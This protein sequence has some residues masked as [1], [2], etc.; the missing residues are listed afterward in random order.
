M[1][2][3]I[4]LI[5]ICLCQIMTLQAET[6]RR[7]VKP[8]NE[9]ISNSTIDGKSWD[10]ASANLQEMIDEVASE[11]EK[12]GK[13]GE[14]W[15]AAGTYIPSRTIKEEFGEFKYEEDG[16]G[17]KNKSFFLKEGVKLYGG[18][19]GN[20]NNLNDRHWIEHKTILSGKFP[21]TN[22]YHVVISVDVKE[23]RLDGFY[24]E[25]GQATEHK[26]LTTKKNLQN[27][28]FFCGHGGGLYIYKSSPTLAQ[29]IIRNN[30]TVQGG[31][32]IYLHE[33]RS[34]IIN[35]LLYGNNATFLNPEVCKEATGAGLFSF[36]SDPI[37]IH[38]TIT[39]NTADNYGAGIDVVREQYTETTLKI[40]NS[41]IYGNTR[42]KTDFTILEDKNFF[43]NKNCNAIIDY[44]LVCTI[45]Q[46]DNV[47][48]TNSEKGDPLFLKDYSEEHPSL[49]YRVNTGSK[50]IDSGYDTHIDLINYPYGLGKAKRKLGKSVDKGAFECGDADPTISITTDEIFLCKEGDISSIEI[51]LTGVAPWSFKYKKNE[52]E[53]DILVDK[54][55]ENPYYLST[56][57]LSKCTI[58]QVKSSTSEWIKLDEPEVA[59]VSLYPSINPGTIDGPSSITIDQKPQYTIK[60]NEK[61]GEWLID[62]TTEDIATINPE[63]GELTPLQTGTV[64]IIYQIANDNDCVYTSEPYV[65]VINPR[66]PPGPNPPEPETPLLQWSV[67][68]TTNAITAFTDVNNDI[69]TEVEEGTPVYLQI[70]PIVDESITYDGWSIIYTAE[71]ADYHYPM[72]LIDE[73]QRYNFNEGNAHILKGTYIYTVERLI[74]YQNG[75]QVYSFRYQDEIIR[76]TIKIN[77]RDEPD[78][79]PD[80]W[81]SVGQI[82]DWCGSENEFRIPFFSPYDKKNLEY[83][84]KFSDEA[85]AAGFEDIPVYTVL[86]EDNYITVPIQSI[87]S[88]GVYVGNILVR[89]LNKEATVDVFPFRI[90]VMESVK[91]VKQPESVTGIC[92]GD[93][94]RLSVEATG[95]RLSYQW[96]VNDKKI[97]GAIY[98]IYEASVSE[99][100]IGDYYVEVY[101]NCGT[102]TSEKVNVS[103]NNFTVLIKWDDVLY[104]QNTDNKFTAF[105]WYKDGQPITKHGTSIYYPI[106][107]T[108]QGSYY[109]RAYLTN[110]TYLESCEITI[111]SSSSSLMVYPTVVQQS[112][113]I[114]IKGKG[115]GDVLKG[116]QIDLYNLSGKLIYT[117][118]ANSSQVE[119]PMTISTGAYILHITALN[120]KKTVEKIFVK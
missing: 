78:P 76:H 22:A 10:T 14:I 34:N 118:K 8:S 97:D 75:Y 20:E 54:I 103:V 90:T 12:S 113:Y 109:V 98:D 111:N 7:Y 33:S 51:V 4:I 31:G 66:T 53:S 107:E 61:K 21:E 28:T 40:Y 79:D 119:I 69:T 35:C 65:V 81:I 50:A 116:A 70:R 67:S 87:I 63:T 115:I 84:I 93:G 23:A 64:K 62:E 38:T 73:K 85:L 24:I 6:I 46:E 3:I 89:E 27:L 72:T 2:K 96:F 41:I 83:I 120:G 48:F 39:D 19:I 29:L 43:V 117:T 56:E 9:I 95:S 74:L 13:E 100:T 36:N 91:I 18:F 102:E 15:V 32:G 108:T 106:D 112:S 59:T 5:V 25:G 45:C 47:S 110:D 82:A 114:T 68:T 16:T 17:D 1:N 57:G 58:T 52:D 88:S 104:I 37:I 11:I 30:E 42:N 60:D 71:P 105:Q 92:E 80:P 101:S 94:F 77:E 44:C 26:S 49:N 99:K 55:E 86:P